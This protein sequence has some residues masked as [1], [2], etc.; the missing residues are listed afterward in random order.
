M[1][2]SRAFRGLSLPL[3]AVSAVAVLLKCASPIL[4]RHLIDG[5]INGNGMAALVAGSVF[6]SMLVLTF[7][8]GILIRWLDG[9]LAIRVRQR[10]KGELF[11]HLLALPEEFLKSKGAGYFFNRVQSDSNEVCLF[12]MGNGVFIWTELLKLA[13][14]MAVVVHVD[15]RFAVLTLPFLAM[16]IAICGKFRKRQYALSSEIQEVIATERH[17]MQEYLSRHSI[18]K[19]HS[20]AD[21]AGERVDKGLKRWGGLFRSRLVNENW[22]IMFL[23]LPVWAC[24]GMVLF[25]GFYRILHGDMTIGALWELIALLGLL[26][27]PT[28]AIGGIFVQM[29]SALAAKGRLDELWGEQ[30]EESGGSADDDLSGDIVFSHLSFRYAD[31]KPLLE[32]VSFMVKAGTLVFLTGPNG[33]GKSTLMSLMLRLYRPQSG[34]ITIGGRNIQDFPLKPYRSGIGYIGQNPEFIKGTLRDNML[35]GNQL[36]SDDEI[37]AAGR[38]AGCTALLEARGLDGAVEENAENF[39]GGEK[40]RLAL[41]RELLRDTEI[42]LFD[43]PAAHLDPESRK[44]FYALVKGLAGRKTIVAV[45]HHLPDGVDAPVVSLPHNAT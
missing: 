13:T 43:E 8:L 39:S 20:A 15:W 33:C 22:F 40:L 14:A 45:V 36:R 4:Q 17:L 10:L 9:L 37:M 44:A 23:Q 11:K 26:F 18:V 21:V 28:K 27:A 3:I 7:G 16:Q 6:A 25:I 30:V 34:S 31:G 32:D 42:L 2:F 24:K 41:L 1:P 12:L 35:I 19:T 29:Q 38:M 5:A